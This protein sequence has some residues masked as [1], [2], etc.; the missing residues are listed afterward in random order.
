MSLSLS[1]LG[2]VVEELARRLPGGQV[3]EIRQPTADAVCLAVRI[4]GE[5]LHLRLEARPRAAWIG[6]APGKCST[7][8]PMP[9][10]LARLRHD[11]TGARVLAVDQPWPDR[12]AVLRLATRDG[13]AALILELSGH[14]SNLFLIDGDSVIRNQLAPSCSHKRELVPGRV[15]MPP[16]FAPMPDRRASRIPS[17]AASPAAAVAALFL[18]AAEDAAENAVRRALLKDLR[19]ASRRASRT[20]LRV[21][22]DLARAEEGLAVRPAADLL[23]SH[24]Y[25]VRRGM[26][27]VEIEDWAAPG[28]R[29]TVP[30]DPRLDPAQ[31]L[32]ALYARYK[33]SKRAVDGIRVRSTA[34]A[35]RVAALEA[36]RQEAADAPADALED[37]RVRADLPRQRGGRRAAPDAPRQPFHAFRSITG[38]RILVG[39]SAADNR[40]L[41][42][43]V[44]RGHDAW[45]HVRGAPGSHVVI[46]L[47]RGQE[48][49]IETLLDAAHLAIRYS[50]SVGEDMADVAWTLRKHVRPASGGR[51]NPGAVFVSREHSLAV[52]WEPGRWDRLNATRE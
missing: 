25:E 10:F 24:L 31:N 52:R 30:L 47:A 5:T 29:V 49:D 41:T 9:R 42:F 7:T 39:R 22:A 16:L 32:E 4:P 20:L 27:S 8:T 46:T 34:L 36:L 3:Q 13:D 45:M 26:D 23:K 17:D 15:Y 1:E 18:S 35:D 50:R 40:R 6:L 33:K 37:L 48:P 12:V 21:E 2:E 43:Q 14:H 28:T 19:A 51:G 38:L 11:L 44:A